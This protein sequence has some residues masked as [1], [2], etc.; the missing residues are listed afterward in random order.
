MISNKN[1]RLDLVICVCRRL[2]DIERGEADLQ[3]GYVL[4]WHRNVRA[5][6]IY[7]RVYRAV[8]ENMY[9]YIIGRGRLFVV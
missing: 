2:V 7:V 3:F 1:E 5:I 8:V 6:H 4:L 9:A